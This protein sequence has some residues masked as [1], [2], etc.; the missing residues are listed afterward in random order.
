MLSQSQYNYL[1]NIDYIHNP[2]LAEN[3]TLIELYHAVIGEEFYLPFLSKYRDHLVGTKFEKYTLNEENNPDKSLL[4]NT[5]DQLFLAN[6]SDVPISLPVLPLSRHFEYFSV[7]LSD[8]W[9]NEKVI[10]V[11]ISCKSLVMLCD[12][13]DKFYLL[14]DIEEVFS[15]FY[16]KDT[17]YLKAIFPVGYNNCDM[18][19]RL[20]DLL[21]DCY[22]IDVINENK[23]FCYYGTFV[24]NFT[25]YQ[26]SFCGKNR[27]DFTAEDLFRNGTSKLSVSVMLD[28][29]YENKEKLPQIWLDRTLDIYEDEID[30]NTESSG[31]RDCEFCYNTTNPK[32]LFVLLDALIESLDEFDIRKLI[33]Y[34]MCFDK[35]GIKVILSGIIRNTTV[36]CDRQL[37]KILDLLYLAKEDHISRLLRLIN[38]LEKSQ[39]IKIEKAYKYAKR[40]VLLAVEQRDKIK[41][42]LAGEE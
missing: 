23:K 8:R 28:Y 13:F 11:D 29:C 18:K 31:H 38:K 10:T 2:L 5:Y 1:Q 40:I 14:E 33:L 12:F 20:N 39:D 4:A 9:K 27:R 34:Y 15:F 32:V 17:A 16:A 26:Q 22:I 36:Y 21:Y 7:L 30:I 37:I 41:E 25:M 42:L 19:N 6:D 3:G 24:S 35:G